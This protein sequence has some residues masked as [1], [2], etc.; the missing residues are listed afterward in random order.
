MAVAEAVRPARANRLPAAV[1]LATLALFA[2]AE[3]A[4]TYV[5]AVLGLAL[6]GLLLSALFVAAGRGAAGAPLTEPLNRLLFSLTLVPLIRILSL[7]LPLARFD[8]AYWYLMAGVPVF[9]ATVV[10]MASLDLRPADVALRLRWSGWHL[11]VVLL[12]C[13]LGIAEYHIL[14]PDPLID[15]LALRQFVLPALILLAATGFLEELLFRGVLQQT[16]TAALGW[17]GVLYV[18]AVF[19]ILHIGYR[20]GIDVAFVFA[21]ALIYGWAVKRTGSIIGVSLSHGVTNIMLFLV[22]PFVPTLT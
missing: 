22:V 16:A 21:I 19:A 10:V 14:R 20:S 7:S 5:N 4:T 2:A 15:G 1:A 6:H 8:Q 13:G 17:A 12:G 9:T 3:I 18:S 11:P